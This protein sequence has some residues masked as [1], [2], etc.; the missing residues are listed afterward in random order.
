[1]RAMDPVGS[2]RSVRTT[3]LFLSH[4]GGWMPQN[5]LVPTMDGAGAGSEAVAAG[6]TP[7]G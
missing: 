5:I 1:M 3:D 2:E 7:P 6:N 4:Q